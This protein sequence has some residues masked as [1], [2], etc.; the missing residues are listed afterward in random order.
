MKSVEGARERSAAISFPASASET[1]GFVSILALLFVLP[2]D[3]G[4]T[5]RNLFFASAVIFF[6]LRMSAG[7]LPVRRVYVFP[8]KPLDLLLILSLVWGMVSAIDA[9]DPSYSLST[10]LHKMVKQYLLYIL[11]FFFIR[12]SGSAGERSR[13]LYFVLVASTIVMSSQAIYEFAQRPVVLHRVDGLTGGIYRLALYFVIALPLNLVLALQGAR[14]VKIICTLASVLG[15]LG[16]YFTFTRGAW[17]ALILEAI[18]IILIMARKKVFWTI[19]IGA[20]AT[21]FVFLAYASVLPKTLVLHPA[22]SD[23]ARAEIFLTGLDVALNH[24]INGIGFGKKSFE[25]YRQGEGLEHTHNLYLNAAVE[26]G[27]VGLGIL[28]AVF[29]V[30]VSYLW[31]AA[32]REPPGERKMLLTG[33]VASVI[34]FLVVSLFCVNYYG[35]A[36]KMLWILIGAGFALRN[37]AGSPVADP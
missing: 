6:L 4:A 5:I 12:T 36:G 29:G 35:W 20:A 17:I 32:E 23:R 25:I 30:V 9:I 33:I 11:T 19:T 24:P 26:T 13:W 28:L 3:L 2:F 8:C 22:W 15:V 18:V 27:F 7:P 1:W 21:S 31:G 16:L 34:G 37:S 10:L 14:Q